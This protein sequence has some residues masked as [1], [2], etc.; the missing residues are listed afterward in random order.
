MPFLDVLCFS[1]LFR[2]GNVNHPTDKLTNTVVE[3]L[4][5]G[6]ESEYKKVGEFD[7]EG[8]ASAEL[9]PDTGRVQAL[10]IRVLKELETWVLIS[11]VRSRMNLL[12][13]FPNEKFS[14]LPN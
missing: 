9:A 3:I 10:K 11:E 8:V 1:F 7:Q 2:T 13:L 14:T 6:S 5:E 12:Y 4:P